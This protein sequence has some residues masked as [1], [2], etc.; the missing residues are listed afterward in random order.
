MTKIETLS[1]MLKPCPF[2]GITAEF[3]DLGLE[4]YHIACQ[5]CGA[6][7][8]ETWGSDETPGDL[9]KAWNRRVKVE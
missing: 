8:G 9:I 3:H 1:K 2:C 6:Q 5:S 4:R 7:V